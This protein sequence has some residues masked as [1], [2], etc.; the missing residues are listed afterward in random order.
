MLKM[1]KEEIRIFSDNRGIG[2][3]LPDS[4]L[5]RLV[6]GPAILMKRA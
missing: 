6:A 5:W 4:I 1:T 3:L 2:A